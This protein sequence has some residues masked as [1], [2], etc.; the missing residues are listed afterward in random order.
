MGV[1]LPRVHSASSS[2]REVVAE[3]EGSVAVQSSELKLGGR[4]EWG[5]GG[6]YGWRA[7]LMCTHRCTHTGTWTRA[8]HAHLHACMY[9]LH[10]HGCTCA[11]YT[12]TSTHTCT[13]RT[14]T[15]ASR[16]FSTRGQQTPTAARTRGPGPRLHTR[17]LPAARTRMHARRHAWMRTATHTPRTRPG[18]PPNEACRCRGGGEVGGDTAG[19]DGEGSG[20]HGWVPGVAGGNADSAR[21]QVEPSR[22]GCGRCCAIWMRPT[23]PSLA[24][25][26]CRTLPRPRRRTRPRPREQN[27]S[28]QHALRRQGPASVAPRRKAFWEL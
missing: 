15:A 27:Y 14:R 7:A 3:P 23:K 8:L 10:M 22:S 18:T 16:A 24:V 26:G 6:G 28:S 17:T 1:I 19:W 2:C 12:C 5:W 11:Q 13:P 4:R 25:T 20:C 9:L 21:P